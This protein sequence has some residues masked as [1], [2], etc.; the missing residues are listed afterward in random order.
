ME[1]AIRTMHKV[2]EEFLW[3]LSHCEIYVP[4]GEPNPPNE[5]VNLPDIQR[6]VEN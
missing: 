6:Y 4:V 5:I 3:K 2:D 1:F